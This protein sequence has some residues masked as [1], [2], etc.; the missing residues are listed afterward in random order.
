MK[1]L[2]VKLLCDSVTN[3]QFPIFENS[4]IE[5]LSEKYQFETWEPGDEETVIRFVCSW[6][7]KKEDVDQ[8]LNDV[9]KLI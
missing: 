2:G 8:L 6:A 5:K 7:T 9:R 4:I 3:Q 1:K